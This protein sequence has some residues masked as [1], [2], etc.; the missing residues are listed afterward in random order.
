MAGG[1]TLEGTS[2][3][4]EV[5]N[6]SHWSFAQSLPVGYYDLRSTILDHHW[7]LMGGN[8]GLT[9][10][11]EKAVHYALLDSLLASCQSSETSQPSSVWK[12]LTDVPYQLC[13]TA[14]FGSTLVAVG[15]GEDITSL[16]PNVYAYSFH[17]NS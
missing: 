9:L 15:G 1:E 17:T 12:R 7:Y 2:N 16:S 10:D 3:I 8:N 4:I 6:G 13:S 11:Q 5:F 14:V